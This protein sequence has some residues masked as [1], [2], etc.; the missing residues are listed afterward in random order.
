MSLVNKGVISLRTIVGCLSRNP[1]RIFGLNSKGKIEQGADAD[2]VL[3][4]PKKRSVVRPEK[5]F[6]KAK[7]SPFEGWKT[8]GQVDT[9]IVG[10]QVIYEQGRIVA[11]S[12]IGAVL[13]RN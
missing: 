3:V 9:T 6:S 7:Y 4:D 11:A 12:G 1:A 13:K 10:G 2:I 8:R 5:F